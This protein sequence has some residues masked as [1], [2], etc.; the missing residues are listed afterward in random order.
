MPLPLA[1]SL[2]GVAV[3]A[4][5]DRSSDLRP[6]GRLALAVVIANAPDLDLVPGVLLGDPNRFHHG[7]THSLL[8]AV[9]VGVALGWAARCRVPPALAR[10]FP[11]GGI[12]TAILVAALWSS[13]VVLDML[14]HDAS[15]P[16]GVL[17][18]WPL[19]DARFHLVDIFERAD[20]VAGPA[21]A[22]EFVRSLLSA[23]NARA[24]LREG[25]ILGPLV[26]AAFW[27]RRRRGPI[28]A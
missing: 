14:T 21:S 25:L 23:H 1:H 5:L 19:S 13:H 7:F 4:T 8:T 22:V 2:A 15:S 27:W 9:A 6:A 12:G 16:M 3:W 11:G 17:A 10:A 18:L 28:E 26:A 24:L 20:K